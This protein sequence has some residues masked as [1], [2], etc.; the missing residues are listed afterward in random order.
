MLSQL[1]QLDADT[2][3]AQLLQKA[4]RYRNRTR[5]LQ[6]NDGCD[7]GARFGISWHKVATKA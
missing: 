1:N 7:V 6:T 2:T 4:L 3:N 5:E